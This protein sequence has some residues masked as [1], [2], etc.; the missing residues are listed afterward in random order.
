MCLP[1]FTLFRGALSSYRGRQGVAVNLQRQV[2]KHK[3]NLARV[4]IFALQGRQELVRSRAAKRTLKICVLDNGNF[5]VAA[6]R[7]GL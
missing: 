5:G 1:E 6:A 2:L 4:N 7:V 3:D